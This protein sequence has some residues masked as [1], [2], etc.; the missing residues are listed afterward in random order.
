M[1]RFI[2]LKNNHI[3]QAWLVISLALVFGG[4]LAGVQ[5][6]LGPRIEA[7]KVN[8]TLERV[9]ELVL[10][11]SL[12]RTFS[13]QNQ[14]L[15]VVPERIEVALNDQT[16]FYSVYLAT[17][18][19]D[20]RGWV[21]KAGGQGYADKIELLIGLD[22]NVETITGLFILDQKETPGLGNK[23]V[24]AEWR[25]Q[26][27]Q[28]PLKGRLKVVKHGADAADEIDAVTGATIS[29]KSVVAIINSAVTDLK[30]PLMAGGTSHSG[31][32]N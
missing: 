29:S 5:L 9:P 15:E 6:T 4:G 17:Y 10:G 1:E 27:N 11:R 28:K 13:A 22:P 24:T 19:G 21:T 16:R 32:N 12:A 2:G 30:G 14:T 7:N 31:R 18:Q 3:L 25:R 26:F 8:E 23:I 20:L